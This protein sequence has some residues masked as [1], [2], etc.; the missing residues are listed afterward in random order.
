LVLSLEMLELEKYQPTTLISS[1]IQMS[2][3]YFL[4]LDEIEQFKYQPISIIW[5]NR[6]MFSD[7]SLEKLRN[8]EN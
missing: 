2:S 4:I 1:Q 8:V 3:K 7:S 5:I 6:C